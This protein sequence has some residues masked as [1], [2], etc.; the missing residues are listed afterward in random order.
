MPVEVL[1]A[2]MAVMTSPAPFASAKRVTPAKE[3]EIYSHSLKIS[4]KILICILLFVKLVIF[5]V[6]FT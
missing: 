2:T 6:Y 4:H 1:D 5:K 3:S